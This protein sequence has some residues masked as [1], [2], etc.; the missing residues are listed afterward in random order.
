MSEKVALVT[1]CNKGIGFATLKKLSLTGVKIFACVR[2]ID[3]KFLSSLNKL[4]NKNLIPVEFD[5]DN[6]DQVKS[7]IAEI[8]SKTKSIDMLVNNAATIDT[9][10]FQMTTESKL[11]KIFETNFFSQL[12]FTQQIAKLMTIKKSGSI[13]FVS[14]TSSIDGDLGRGA[15]ASTKSALNSIAKVMSRELGNYNIRVNCIPS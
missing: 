1:G 14:S 11:K 9:A 6:K 13:V 8:K 10:L 4:K 7:A 2:K 3:E 15:Y 12:Y 5:L